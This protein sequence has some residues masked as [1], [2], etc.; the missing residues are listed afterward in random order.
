MFIDYDYI[1]TIIRQEI[2][3]ALFERGLKSIDTDVRL[4]RLL[5]EI[6]GIALHK[7]TCKCPY[8]DGK[9]HAN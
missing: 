8:K 4:E 7:V 3:D 5:L 1:R 9:C 2:G 6:K